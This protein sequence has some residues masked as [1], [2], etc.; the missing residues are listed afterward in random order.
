V[1]IGR[2]RRRLRTD[3]LDDEALR[4]K[5]Q[6]DLRVCSCAGCS[7]ILGAD[8]KP[9]RS[10]AASILVAMVLLVSQGASYAVAAL[11][12]AGNGDCGMHHAAMADCCTHMGH[13]ADCEHG[14]GAAPCGGSPACGFACAACAHPVAYLDAT[15]LQISP[16]TRPSGRPPTDSRYASRPIAPAERP[17]RSFLG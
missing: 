15:N 13:A 17:P 16:V 11:M 6:G 12:P 9:V 3:L 7:P 8:M 10:P 14:H 4:D 5:I 1:L 2:L